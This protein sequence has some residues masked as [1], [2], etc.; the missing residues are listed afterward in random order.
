MADHRDLTLQIHADGRW[1]DAARLTV[2]DPDK[3]WQRASKLAY[4]D[5]WVFE[6]DPDFT[7]SVQGWKALSVR[8]PPSLALQ[9]RFSFDVSLL[10]GSLMSS[11]PE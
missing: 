4:D 9:L 10:R 2:N 8:L 1:S 7:G 3:G 11:S 5:A 6:V